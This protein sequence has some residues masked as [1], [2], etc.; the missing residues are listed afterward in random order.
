MNI[1]ELIDLCERRLASLN[2]ER[3]YAFATGDAPSL[4]TLDEQVA[5]TQATIDRLKTLV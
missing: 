4:S 3:A 5:T 2:N 1:Q